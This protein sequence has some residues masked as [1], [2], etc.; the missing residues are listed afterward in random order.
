MKIYLKDSVWL[1]TEVSP[2]GIFNA[3]QAVF[4]IILNR[5]ENLP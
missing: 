4:P 3:K 2:V 5:I 1:S